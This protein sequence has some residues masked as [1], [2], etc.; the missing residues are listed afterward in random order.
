MGNIN[1]VEAAA[2]EYKSPYDATR[3]YKKN[4]LSLIN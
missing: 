2:M 3:I 4:K 1:Q